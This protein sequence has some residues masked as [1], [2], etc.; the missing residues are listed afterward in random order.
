MCFLALVHLQNGNIILRKIKARIPTYL[1]IFR[2]VTRSVS[3]IWGACLCL[4]PE[5]RQIFWRLQAELKTEPSLTTLWLLKLVL[6]FKLMTVG[7]TSHPDFATCSTAG[8]QIPQG[9]SWTLIKCKHTMAVS[10]RLHSTTDQTQCNNFS[11]WQSNLCFVT[12]N[13][14]KNPVTQMNIILIQLGLSCSITDNKSGN[15]Q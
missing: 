6:K 13:E 3:K 10:S 8:P 12:E 15:K 2:C 14:G 4:I 1:L 5:V 9:E 11:A 7:N